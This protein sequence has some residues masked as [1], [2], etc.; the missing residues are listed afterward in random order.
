MDYPIITPVF[1]RKFTQ[2]YLHIRPISWLRP[3]LFYFLLPMSGK[4]YHM[5]YWQYLLFSGLAKDQ[6]KSFFCEGLKHAIRELKEE[7]EFTNQ[8]LQTKEVSAS[9]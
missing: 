2:T 9:M 8:K 5:F 4:I 6:G 7:L 3:R 1:H